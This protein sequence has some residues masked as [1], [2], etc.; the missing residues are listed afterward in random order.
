MC[1]LVI[2]SPLAGDMMEK[3][4]EIEVLNG[5]KLKTE[6]VEERCDDGEPGDS[7]GALTSPEQSCIGDNPDVNYRNDS[8]HVPMTDDGEAAIMREDDLPAL[9]KAGE[10]PEDGPESA[11]IPRRSARLQGKPP[12]TVTE[13]ILADVASRTCY[14]L[15]YFRVEIKTDNPF[16]DEPEPRTFYHPTLPKKLSKAEKKLALSPERVQSSLR[17]TRPAKDEGDDGSHNLSPGE[18]GFLQGSNTMLAKELPTHDTPSPGPGDT[19]SKFDESWPTSER[20][21]TIESP[22]EIRDRSSTSPSMTQG[23]PEMS[24]LADSSASKEETQGQPDSTIGRLINRF[25]FGAPTSRAERTVKSEDKTA[26]FWWLSSSSSPPSQLLSSSSSASVS[27]QPSGGTTPSSAKGSKGHTGQR[28][29]ESAGGRGRES[30]LGRGRGRG[31]DAS[32]TSSW[33]G[34]SRRS[35]LDARRMSGVSTLASSSSSSVKLSSSPLDNDTDELQRRADKLLEMSESTILTDPMVSSDGLG[36]SSA[37]STSPDDL[38]PPLPDAYRSRISDKENLPRPPLFPANLQFTQRPQRPEDDILQQ[39]RMRR[40]MEEATGKGIG[41]DRGK[42]PLQPSSSRQTSTVSKP[43]EESPDSKLAE[44]RRRLQQQRLLSG[45]MATGHIPRMTAGAGTGGTTHT[46]TDPIPQAA[47]TQTN[48]SMPP[49]DDHTHG[50]YTDTGAYAECPKKAARILHECRDTRPHHEP[51]AVAS[52]NVDPPPRTG[53]AWHRY[54]GPNREP[55]QH[56]DVVPHIHLACDI[57]PCDES[58]PHRHTSRDV[59]ARLARWEH[60]VQPVRDTTRMVSEDRRRTE[61]DHRQSHPFSQSDPPRAE[62]VNHRD[63]ALVVGTDP[64]SRRDDKW[65]RDHPDRRAERDAVPVARQQQS[66][67]KD[68]EGG[69]DDQELD[70]SPIDRAIGQVI[71]S[72]MF[73]S[74]EGERSSS[75][76]LQPL[77]GE[78]TPPFTPPRELGRLEDLDDGRD[79]GESRASSD[80]EEFAGDEMLRVLRAQ[81]EECIRKLNRLDD[82][83]AHQR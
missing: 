21:S 52:P 18:K 54:S 78:D 75:P 4:A 8:D 73:A 53:T 80:G 28:P 60:Q 43:A 35:T 48:G 19:S 42:R 40:R 31:R 22:V 62:T 39:W 34:T 11:P 79:R 59:D 65:E 51:I 49:L 29:L 33:S 37:T 24:S 64:S 13:E 32:R 47:S 82:L 17:P 67:S 6:R 2:N 44:F 14:Y 25:R 55:S 9:E 77:P 71:A 68:A 61:P 76:R 15:L 46:G 38:T 50:S 74:P 57:L 10:R 69:A 72:R 16:Y 5:S 12:P 30:T 81:R 20:P 63:E 1:S 7:L 26:S 66:G 70:S 23:V 45:A 83:L 56:C 27:R 58:R 36:P 41:R 3:S